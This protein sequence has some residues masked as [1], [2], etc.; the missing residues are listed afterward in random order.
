MQNTNFLVNFT[1]YIL[2]MIGVSFIAFIVWKNM[3]TIQNKA[4]SSMKIE[5]SLNLAPRKDLYIIRINDERFLIASDADKTTFL[6]KLKD[7][8]TVSF[9]EVQEEVNKEDE[10]NNKIKKIT[11]KIIKKQ[12]DDLIQKETLIK[13]EEEKIEAKN[14]LKE[15]KLRG[16]GN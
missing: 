15:L 1:V 14:V 2:A 9:K 12:T 10:T 16:V 8:K 11:E 5:D 13:Q 3:R 4:K 7:D 6:S